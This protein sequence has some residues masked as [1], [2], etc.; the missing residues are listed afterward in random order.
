[1]LAKVLSGAVL[2]I[3]AYIVKVELDIS[4]GLPSFNTVGLPDVAIKEARDRVPAAIK[5]SASW[6]NWGWMVVFVP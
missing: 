6:A 1:M 2:G 5:N 4:K 3:D